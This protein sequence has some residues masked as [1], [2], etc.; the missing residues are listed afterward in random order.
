MRVPL[1]SGSRL[2]PEGQGFYGIF[3]SKR[4]A[5]EGHVGNRLNTIRQFL[6]EIRGGDRDAF[7]AVVD[8]SYQHYAL[9]D[10]LTTQVNVACLAPQAGCKAIDLYLIADPV[11]PA[12]P[13][14]SY[15]NNE[16]YAVHLDRLFAAF[17]CLREVRSVRI[18]RDAY[19]AGLVWTSIVA[20][21]T[22]RWPAIRDHLRHRMPYPMGHDIINRFHARERHIPQLD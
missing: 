1:S 15:I 21:G 14:Q 22:P 18:L 20:S 16:N 2:K 13:T 10:A 19:A 5:R 11:Y 9:G 17:L 4:D 8:F 7:A 3:G 12:A 6:G